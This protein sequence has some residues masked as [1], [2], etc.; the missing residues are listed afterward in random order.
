MSRGHPVGGSK[1][2]FVSQSGFSREAWTILA[3]AL[4]AQAIS[5]SIVAT[6]GSP[7]GVKYTV[8]GPIDTPGDSR[9]MMRTVRI[10]EPHDLR[11]RLVIAHPL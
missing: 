7:Y 3:A 4:G 8:D 5:N 2:R 11:P 1:A 6:V 9:P 10:V